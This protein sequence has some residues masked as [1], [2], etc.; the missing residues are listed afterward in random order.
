M[1]TCLVPSVVFAYVLLQAIAGHKGPLVVWLVLAGL[2]GLLFRV[3]SG[4]A[5][6]TCGGRHTRRP[7]GRPRRR[8]AGDSQ[9]CEHGPTA[10]TPVSPSRHDV[11]G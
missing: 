8:P 9:A 5:R 2:S 3:A 7:R 1:G 6:A 4:N 11:V 10:R